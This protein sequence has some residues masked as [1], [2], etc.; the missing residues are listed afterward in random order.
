MS[1]QAV[2]DELVNA[3]AAPGASAAWGTAEEI[4]FA[5]SGRFT[6]AQDSQAVDEDTVFD[7]ASLTKPIAVASVCMV[8]DDRG[9]FSPGESVDTGLP[10]LAGKGVT[11]KNLLRHDSGAAAYCN[12]EGKGLE[13][14]RARA[15]ILELGDPNKLGGPPV[16]SCIGYIRL[17]EALHRTTKKPIDAL[18]NELV[19]APLETGFRYNPGL[20]G[21]APTVAWEP[22]RDRC[23]ARAGRRPP[24]PWV[25]G[26]VH[27]PLAWLQRGVSGNAGLFGSARDVA[28]YAKAILGGGAPF[29]KGVWKRYTD[30]A[31]ANAD[32][33][34]GWHLKSTVG[35]SAGPSWGKRSVGH[36]GFTGTMLWIDPDQRFFAA[37]L[38]SAVHPDGD[39]EPL[40]RFRV[41]F[42]EAATV[43]AR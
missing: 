26:E 36:T 23:L 17:A 33:V 20:E 6:Y 43:D 16:Y 32:R 27:D 38:A 11:Y 2:L 25:T 19:N 31:G 18:F 21:V 5:A 37:L 15:A 42:S 34:L 12:L 8:L 22:W 40:K 7:L 30:P 28:T 35:S 10:E 3:R 1:V 39:P 41:K 24:L 9:E 4:R 13:G 29:S 14:E